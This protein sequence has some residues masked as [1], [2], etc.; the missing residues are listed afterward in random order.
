[1]VCWEL[2]VCAGWAF[3]GGEEETGEVRLD[4]CLQEPVGRADLL[5]RVF[6][7][8]VLADEVCCQ[9]SWVSSMVQ[10]QQLFQRVCCASVC[11]SWGGRH[12]GVLMIVGC[13]SGVI[14]AANM[15]FQGVS[16]HGSAS[17]LLCSSSGC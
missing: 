8:L 16:V 4:G 14:E 10:E 12:G 3:V 2:L 7:M 15:W 5:L 11:L 13:V 6:V 17:V 1:M 9:A